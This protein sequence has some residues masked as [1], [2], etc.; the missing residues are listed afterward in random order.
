MWF[1]KM[2]VIV[3]IDRIYGTPEVD[4]VIHKVKNQRV[5][6]LPGTVKL[7]WDNGIY[8]CITAQV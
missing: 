3:S 5:M 7:R 4:V 2:D 8:T 6:G 1:N